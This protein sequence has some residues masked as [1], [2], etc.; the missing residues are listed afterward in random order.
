MT[1]AGMKD[2]GDPVSI[3]ILHFH[4]TKNAG[5]AGQLTSAID[6]L[7]AHFNSPEITVS[8]NFPHEPLLQSLGIKVVPSIRSWIGLGRDR[9]SN[10]QRFAFI[11]AF[12]KIG[13]FCLIRNNPPERTAERGEWSKILHSYRKADLI[14]STPGNIFLSMGRFGFPFLCSALAVLPAICLQKPF[15]VM[16]QTVGPLYKWWER[17]IVKY[18]YSRA[19]LLFL[20]EPKS[21][22]LMRKIGFEPTRLKLSPDQSMLVPPLSSTEPPQALLDAGYLPDQVSIGVTTIGKLLQTISDQ[23]LKH[24]YR[25]LASSLSSFIES[26]HARIY[27]FPQV[28]GPE[29]HEDDRRASRIVADLMTCPEDSY[30]IIDDELSPHELRGAYQQMDAFIASRLH[31]AIFSMSAAVPTLLIGYLDK[32]AG[33][34]EMYE[35]EEYF[36]ELSTLQESSLSFK[37]NQL[38]ENR[39]DLHSQLTKMHAQITADAISPGALIFQD[40]SY[41]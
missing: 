24:Y 22:R 5:D 32:A 21:E 13:A 23:D 33:L 9:P 6:D 10:Q 15:Y 11:R 29:E 34:A 28:T 35:W 4:S 7:R 20:R 17:S 16:P 27:F 19:R 41:G 18:L 25:A 3:L 38:W 1:A 26:H 2:T 14:I 31:S 40:Y 37:L 12:L 36:L 8:A 39:N 30:C